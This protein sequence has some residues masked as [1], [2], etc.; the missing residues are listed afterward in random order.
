[1]AGSNIILEN[2]ASAIIAHI[3]AVRGEVFILRAVGGL[4]LAKK[5]DPIYQDDVVSTKE[6]AAALIYA[7]SGGILTFGS[8]AT[9][10]FNP[11]LTEKINN[12]FK[13]ASFGL[14]QKTTE[15]ELE[16]LIVDGKNIEDILKPTAA[17]EE[18]DYQGFSLSTQSVIVWERTADEI[19]PVSGFKASDIKEGGNQIGDLIQ[20]DNASIFGSQIDRD[21]EATLKNLQSNDDVLIVNEDS[22]FQQGS[23][24]NNDTTLNGSVLT[25]RL[26]V[27][28]DTQHG[29]LNFNSDGSY[30]YKPNPNYSGSDIFQYV[31]T[32]TS[33]NDS[34][35]QTVNIT[36][37]P[38]NDAPVAVGELFTMNE[39]N[40]LATQ[41]L[42]NDSDIDGDTLSLNTTPVTD[43]NNGTLILNTDGTF[44]YTP[45]EHF[46]GVDSFVYE[47]TDGNG[48]TAQATVNITVDSVADTPI[49]NADTYNVSEDGS[50]SA[51]LINGVL[52]ND[53]DGDGDTLT[54]NVVPVIDVS[55]GI[56]VLSA[57]GTFTYTPDA[58]FHGVDSF[59]YAIDDGNGNTSQAVVN[60]TVDPVADIPEA[61]TDSYVILEDSVLNTTLLNGVLA[62]DSDIDGD[63]LSLNTTPVTDANNGTLILNTDG[64]FTYTPNEHFHGVDSFVYEVTDGN[65]G[66]AQAT[67]NITVDSVADTPVAN[68]D[69][70][71]VSEDGSLSTTL[72]NGVLVN[73]SDGDGDTLTVNVVP[74]IDVSHG[75][76][77]LSADGTFTYTPDANFHGIDSFTYEIDD[78]NGGVAQATA[79]ITVT[80]VTDLTTDSENEIVD[81]DNPLAS[82]V[83]TGDSTTSGGALSYSLVS[84]PSHGTFSSAINP[85]TGAYT[86]QPNADY[87]GSDSFQ[88]LV[89][90]SASGESAVQTVSITVNPVVDLTSMDDALIVA[91]DTLTAGDVSLNDTTTSSGGDVNLTFT[92]LTDPTNGVLVFNSDG[93]YT[94]DPTD[95]GVLG[96]VDS[97]TYLVTD[98]ASGESA[99]Q[100]VNLTINPANTPPE[101]TDNAAT[102]D[103]DTAYTLLVAD[104]GFSDVVEGDTFNGV[105]IDTLPTLGALTLAGIAVTASQIISAASIIA[106]DLVFTPAADGYG[107]PYDN[108][109]FSVRDS[110]GSIDTVPNTFTLHV[111]PIVDLPVAE[112]DTYE[113]LVNTPFTATLANGVLLND[114]DADG[115]TLTV[116]TT[117]V[118]DVSGGVLVLNSDGTFTY[119]PNLDFNGTD[120]FVYEIDDGTGNTTQATANITVD[121]VSNDIIGT[122][123][124]DNLVGA[125]FSDDDIY[126]GGV[127][128]GAENVQGVGGTISE[129]QFGHAGSGNDRLIFDADDAYSDNAK[130]SGGSSGHI[131]IRDFTVGD[132]TSDTDADTLVLGDFLRAGDPTFDGSAEDAVRFFHFVNDK[133]LYI[134]REGG[135]GEAGDSARDLIDGNYKG[136]SG[137]ASLFLEFKG[138]AFD[139]TPFGETLNTEVQIQ[140]LMD[141]GFLDFS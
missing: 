64:T 117:P 25:Y 103:E 49:A 74:V 118:S 16:N 61:N 91:Y 28:S 140:Q 34:E 116:D 47:V 77:V 50:L 75:I 119:T 124:A 52:V 109:T 24:S 70:Y 53:S 112:D 90:D 5:G 101:G 44:T 72:I 51:T 56:L 115:D 132:V 82:T 71:N 102:I 120:S 41:L 18:A 85:V 138:I 20:L 98:P 45:N 86:Y 84:G 66:T 81:E 126:S 80:G 99:T 19:V 93:T 69:T 14:G 11:S 3:G 96:G 37:T 68:A 7:E 39:D 137:G 15:D 136:I 79:T 78:G 6:N 92:K 57:D 2:V 122:A 55:H 67:V 65:G 59:T 32:D 110:A 9:V 17:N 88:Y 1:M 94:Y 123:G 127:N 139:A 43:A 114:S 63:T 8:S 29:E 46:H 106:G 89:T 130:G 141:Y 35:V 76:L 60:I 73:D 22:E 38:R 36:V 30:S 31:V 131:R 83:T 26:V 134:D 111:D 135:L 104:F 4:S 10:R 21:E 42:S 113:V 107:T 95:I 27:G 48:A 128:S 87:V 125:E 100:T 105:R 40:V 121:Y 12:E 97:F 108:F 54:V 129:A 133:L 58:N 33:S 62:N 13:Y 23:V